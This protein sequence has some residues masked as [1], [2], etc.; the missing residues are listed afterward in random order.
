MIERA[1]EAFQQGDLA[2][3]RTNY[4]S[5]LQRDATSRDALL[6]LAAID[7]RMRE[8]A[9]AAARYE[10][11]LE[12]D[13]RDGFAQAGMLALRRQADPVQS[14]SRIK[15]LIATNPETT[16]LYF[17]LGNEYAQQSLWS[18]A[19]AAY[20][21]AYSTDPDNPD[22]AYNLAV[23]LDHLRQGRQAL[24]YYERALILAQ[25]RPS[26]FDREQTQSRIREL[27]R[28]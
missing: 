10:K 28:E 26:G 18:E 14:E 17:N 12:L 24:E 20:F 5:A 7:V 4:E 25:K 27:R 15:T 2:A 8:F 9:L 3:A 13:P 16:P 11:L 23:S 22:Y 6:G 1:Y 19:Q 21:K